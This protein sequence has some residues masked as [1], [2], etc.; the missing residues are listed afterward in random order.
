M[1]EDENPPE[2]SPSAD[3]G[4]SDLFDRVREALEYDLEA[5]GFSQ[6]TYRGKEPEPPERLG[7]LN[8]ETLG[9][10]YDTYL[11]F[12]CYT[13]NLLCRAVNYLGVTD[14]KV[15]IAKAR[16]L[17]SIAGNKSYS[18]AELRDAYVTLDPE[19]VQTTAD[20]TYFRS[21]YDAQEERRRKLSKILERIFREMAFRHGGGIPPMHSQEGGS[22]DPRQAQN[23]LG[24]TG[25]FKPVRDRDR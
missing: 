5:S 18:N 10:L 4:Q 15:K 6:S 16:A 24:R 3:T 25:G 7:A 21:S 13:S 14:A 23:S 2:Q 17:L 11:S 8:L 22:F 1:D 20:Y 12:Y 9:D 19:V